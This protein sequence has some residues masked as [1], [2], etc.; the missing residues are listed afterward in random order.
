MIHR[1][2]HRLK[3]GL[4]MYDKSKEGP[5]PEDLY[6]KLIH[7]IYQLCQWG[8]PVSK[9]IEIGRI[10]VENYWRDKHADKSGG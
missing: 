8:V 4:N 2:A 5:I 9:G 1:C 3:G 7:A 10:I 6:N